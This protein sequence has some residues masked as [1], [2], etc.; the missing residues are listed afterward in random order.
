MTS[1]QFFWRYVTYRK[2]LAAALLGC[3]LGIAAADL[4]FPWLLQQGIDTALGELTD[5]SLGTIALWMLGVVVVL[6]AAHALMLRIETRMLCEA[7]YDLRRRLYTHFHTQAIAF[8]LRHKTGEL[9]YR[10]SSDADL[11]EESAVELFSELPFALMTVVGVLTLM[12]V[13]DVRLTGLVLLFFSVAS[14]VTAYFGRPLPTLRKSI[15]AIHARLS[16]R[17]QETLSGV[18]TVQAFKNESYEL[19][20]L[21]AANRD[22]LAVEVREGKLEALIEPVFEI[23]ELLGVILVVW[24]GGTL[25]LHR[26]ITAGTLVAFMAYME[27]LTGPVSRVGEFYRHFQ[28][29]RAFGDRL[30]ALLDDREILPVSAGERP[31]DD[32]WDVIIDAVS[33]R[34]P[35]TEREVLLD[36]SF[37]VKHGETV[38]V[39]GRN[40][41]GKST[42]MDLLMRFYDP[43]SGRIIAGGVD[44]GAWD[45]EAW[46]RSVGVM[47]QEAFLFHGTVAENI[48]YGRPGASRAEI[49]RAAQ[50][51]GA[52]RLVRRL[53]RGFDSVVGE[54]GAKLSG[55]ERQ[56]VAL[57]RLFLRNPNVLLLDEPTAHLDGEALH[58]L[59]AALDRLTVGR[60]TFLV[61]HRP[62]TIPL[63]SRIVLLDR[64]RV[65]A[66]GTHEVLWDDQPLYRQL[67]S[68]KA[69]RSARDRI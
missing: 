68:P 23:V 64:G 8:F 39:V 31:R 12:A 63:A 53:P 59:G 10:V 48:A 52:E 6:Y 42:L 30:Q 11:F 60:T 7:S 4:T 47:T 56:L 46:R 14:V 43:T 50:E 38:A 49:E 58:Q 15:Q 57:A 36:V 62:E 16:S 51:S 35:G 29:C 34:Y 19:S 13:T 2:D 40:G 69:Q 28:I 18:R 17:L 24:Y 9:M 67:L 5:H 65:V 37:T 25:I 27:L 41:A 55:G 3:A 45:L 32:S 21:D 61:S 66:E 26:Q 54:R 20:R 1:M 22:I 33:F 44:L